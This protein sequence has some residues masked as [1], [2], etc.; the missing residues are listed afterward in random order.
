MDEATEPHGDQILFVGSKIE[1]EGPMCKVSDK[2]EVAPVQGSE[3][4]LMYG[5]RA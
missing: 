3:R 4:M 5:R 1:A 2:S